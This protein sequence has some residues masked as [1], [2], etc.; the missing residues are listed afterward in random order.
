[1]TDVVTDVPS[2]RAIVTTA[3]ES[4]SV[5]PIQI[6]VEPRTVNEAVVVVSSD[7]IP[8][9]AVQEHSLC[10]DPL[11]DTE[12][13]RDGPVTTPA[14]RPTIRELRGVQSPPVVSVSE[15]T[16]LRRTTRTT[17]CSTSIDIPLNPR[18]YS[19][20]VESHSTGEISSDESLG[21]DVGSLSDSQ[22]G[23]SQLGGALV[24]YDASQS[25]WQVS[26]RRSQRIG[27]RGRAGR[28][29][30]GGGPGRGTLSV[31]LPLLSDD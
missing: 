10:P 3:G 18:L 17:D 5:V 13:V 28:G 8:A 4:A 30:R 12:L 21:G 24:P 25:G 14:V 27:K 23:I 26:V 15:D 22:K 20:G 19:A 31:V 6:V 11:V 1:M 9:S 29:G 2:P 16:S 7:T